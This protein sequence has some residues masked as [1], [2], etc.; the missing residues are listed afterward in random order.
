MPLYDYHCNDCGSEFEL[1][2]KSSTV[3]A[4]PGCGSQRL[5]KRLAL[6][7]PAGRSAGLLAQ[8]RTQAAREGHFS[9]Y[10]PSELPRIRK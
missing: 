6:T 4:C 2:V 3:P 5:D 8:A 10:R 9:H 7:A 1:L